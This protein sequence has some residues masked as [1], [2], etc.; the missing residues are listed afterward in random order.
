[1]TT[2]QKV[3]GF[4][5][6]V[7]VVGIIGLT[8]MAMCKEDRIPLEEV[9]A[10]IDQI[11]RGDAQAFADWLGPQEVGVVAPPAVYACLFARLP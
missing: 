3:Y 9:C 5:G 4:C 11:P 7:M 10:R 6:L 1:M 8:A 2:D